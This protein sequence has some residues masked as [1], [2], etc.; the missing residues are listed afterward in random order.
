MSCTQQGVA[1]QLTRMLEYKP[2]LSSRRLACT[3]SMSSFS[4]ALTSSNTCAMTN[5][6][7]CSCAAAVRPAARR[8]AQ[9]AHERL[10]MCSGPAYTFAEI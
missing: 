5:R 1:G 9:G 6:V 3:L 2:T 7:H 10:T 8:P 4:S